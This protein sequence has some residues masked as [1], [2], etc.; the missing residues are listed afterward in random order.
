MTFE[1]SAS[2]FFDG[3]VDAQQGI[4]NS[5]DKAVQSS[6]GVAMGIGTS[7]ASAELV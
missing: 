4:D 6:A 3:F 5:F 7:V 1:E 2:H